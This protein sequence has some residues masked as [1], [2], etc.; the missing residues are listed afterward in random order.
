[1]ALRLRGDPAAFAPRLTA[2]AN[3]ADPTLRL[4]GLT[5][6]DELHEGVLKMI[7]IYIGIALL[8]SAI[9][10]LLSLA[11]IYAVT[12]FAVSRRTREIGIRVAL[13]AGAPHVMFAVFRRPLMQVGLG[14]VVGGWLVAQLARSFMDGLSAREIGLIIAYASL[15][16]AVCLF[17]C[18]NPT[19]RALGIAPTEALREDG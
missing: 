18:I 6:M 2:I 14:V 7:A 11:G 12:S 15:M 17:A 8:V 3:A 9:A 19:R 10:L 1:V 13:G 4:Y 5:P 16:L